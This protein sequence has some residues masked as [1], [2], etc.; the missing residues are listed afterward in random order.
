MKC[1]R[2]WGEA[3]TA[4]LIF[5]CNKRLL[6]LPMTKRILGGNNGENTWF[7]FHISTHSIWNY[8]FV[9]MLW[10]H[11]LWL[12]QAEFTWLI[13]IS[14]K[15]C[16]I[17]HYD[18]IWL[19]T[20]TWLRTCES[21][22]YY[23]WLIVLW[24]TIVTSYDVMT[25]AHDSC[26]ESWVSHMWLIWAQDLG[27]EFW[28]VKRRLWDDSYES[29]MDFPLWLIMRDRSYVTRGDESPG[30]GLWEMAI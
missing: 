4:I 28:L 15:V 20:F 14:H 27:S 8:E 1:W 29:S 23:D 17:L 7:Y 12:S 18:V 22:L 25:F 21:W 2:H 19:I 24:L 16:W 6:A 26:Y 5:G 13:L 10:C 30:L 11:K 3:P 9:H